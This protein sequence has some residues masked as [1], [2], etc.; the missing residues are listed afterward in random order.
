MVGVVPTI[1]DFLHWSV[2]EKDMDG[3]DERD[4][5]GWCAC[6]TLAANPLVFAG[7]FGRY[8][9]Q[10]GEEGAVMTEGSPSKR[11]ADWYFDFVSPFAYLQFMAEMPRLRER[12]D[13]TCVPVLFAGLLKSWGQLGPAEI[14]PKRVNISSSRNCA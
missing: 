5:D 1:R 13:V 4:H 14:P 10:A 7:Y 2:Q 11:P 9:E 3:R 6:A 12:L 8:A